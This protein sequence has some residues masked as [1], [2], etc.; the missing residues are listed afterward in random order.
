MLLQIAVAILAFILTMVAATILVQQRHYVRA[1]V[2]FIIGTFLFLL[3]IIF[4]IGLVYTIL[5]YIAGGALIAY[6]VVSTVYRLRRIQTQRLRAEILAEQRAQAGP[7]DSMILGAVAK[8][9]RLFGPP[10]QRAPAEGDTGRT[11]RPDKPGSGSPKPL[12]QGDDSSLSSAARAVM[13]RSRPSGAPRAVGPTTVD[14]SPDDPPR[15]R[16]AAARPDPAPRLPPQTDALPPEPGTSKP[17]GHMK[18][19]GTEHINRLARRR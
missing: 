8:G 19:R 15:P 17:P 11:T 7:V 5:L 2:T 16:E 12:R 6:A 3:P 14:T 1:A 10:E 4:Q 18:G 13:R 9:G